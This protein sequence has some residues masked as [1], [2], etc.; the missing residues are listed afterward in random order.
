MAL[1]PCRECKKKVSTEA[2][3]CPNCGAPDPTVNLETKYEIVWCEEISCKSRHKQLKIP[4]ILLGQ[5]QCPVCESVMT[6][7]SKK[8]LAQLETIKKY[9][10]PHKK[11]IS[12]VNKRE[13][14]EKKIID[15]H[16]GGRSADY[17]VRESVSKGNGFW[18]GNE[19]LAKTFW[20]YFIVGNMIG[21]LMVIVLLESAFL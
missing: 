18:N 8:Q 5:Q 1:K 13:A 7:V 3:T 11:K 10:E 20:L 16:Y 12:D 14:A 21:N 6:L 4:T 15:K 17:N 19:G 9:L 2:L